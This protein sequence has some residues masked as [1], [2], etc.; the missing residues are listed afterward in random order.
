MSTNKFWFWPNHAIGK[1]ESGVLREQHN[2]LANEHHALL[3]IAKELTKWESDPARYG[4]DLAGLAPKGN[5][6]AH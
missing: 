5:R 1:R 4:G 2:Q 6:H 3:E